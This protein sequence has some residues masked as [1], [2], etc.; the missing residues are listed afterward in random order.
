MKDDGEE[1]M[2][3][4]W[5]HCFNP[6][7]LPLQRSSVELVWRERPA[8]SFL[9]EWSDRN[10][11]YSQIKIDDVHELLRYEWR[12]AMGVK[13][14]GCE[15]PAL[16]LDVMVKDV[17]QEQATSFYLKQRRPALVWHP[18]FSSVPACPFCPNRKTTYLYLG[19]CAAWLSLVIDSSFPQVWSLEGIFLH[20]I[21]LNE[22]P[23]SFR[24]IV[25]VPDGLLNC[26]ITSILWPQQ[27][28]VRG[29]EIF[30]AVISGH[31]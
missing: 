19:S 21:S 1:R 12:T 14:K 7:W 16:F 22:I 31:T 2:T 8:T 29:V 3:W 10:D 30:I 26:W 15:G 28:I 6:E 20:H 17:P 13:V 24:M 27:T 18:R 23:L 25:T 5:S 11:R 9:M 4:K